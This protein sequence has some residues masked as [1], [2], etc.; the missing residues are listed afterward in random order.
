[1][2]ELGNI[3]QGGGIV[4]SGA[5][6]YKL[7]ELAYK[8]WANRNQK[9]KIEPQPLAVEA[10]KREEYVRREDFER[11]V[12]ENTREHENFFA[13]INRNDR[14]TSE[15]K[16]LLMGIRDDLGMIKAKLFKSGGK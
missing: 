15:I 8:V 10:H 12:A 2:S 16:G 1:V 9:T 5:L 3:I 6:A 13:R 7:L 4:L 14:E 11:H